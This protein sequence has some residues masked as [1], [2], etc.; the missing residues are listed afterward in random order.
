M[1]NTTESSEASRQRSSPEQG[2]GLSGKLTQ[3]A[4][5]A[6]GQAVERIQ[7]T[8]DRFGDE[9][10]RRRSRLTERIRDVR[11]VLESAGRKLGEDDMVSDGLHYV[12]RKVDTLASYVETAEPEHLASDLRELARDRPGWFFGGTFVLGLALGRFVHAT[13]KEAARQATASKPTTS[14][15]V[16]GGVG[17]RQDAAASPR[18]AEPAAPRPAEAGHMEGSGRGPAARPPQHGPGA[19]QP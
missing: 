8:R 5:E 14:S 6:T 3:G 16:R 13:G 9:L 12:S 18:Q 19:R 17:V 10:S 1:A 11:D 7:K 2:A 15:T 4:S